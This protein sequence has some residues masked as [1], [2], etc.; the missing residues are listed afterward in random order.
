MKRILCLLLIILVCAAFAPPAHADGAVTLKIDDTNV[1]D[2]M[3]KS[4]QDGYVPRV[5]NG[6]ATLV[7]PL[8]ATGDISG[9]VITATPNLGDASSS[10]FVFKNYQKTI[11]L[12]DN[13]V[14]GGGTVSSYLVRFDFELKS[15]RVNGVYPVTTDISAQTADGESVQRS[16]T[17]YVTITDGKNP[18]APDKTPAPA[19]QPKI[20]ISGY[21][22][23]PDPVVA[24]GEFTATVTLKNTSDKKA[25]YNAFVTVSCDS[26]NFALKNESSTIPL[27]KIAKD[28][29]VDIEISYKTDL[30]TPAQRYNITLMMEYDNSDA[31]T[32][33]SQGTVQVEVTQPLNV[34]MD[35]PRIPESVNAGDTMSLS[36][37]VMNMGRSKVYNARIEISAPGLLPTKTAFIGDIEA[38]TA[39]QG[40][41]DIF[42]GMKSMTEGYKGEDKY[43]PTSGKI[44]LIYEDEEGRP[45]T[46][47]MDIFTMINEPVIGQ[48]SAKPEE[49]PDKESQW[50]ISLLI[51]G[52]AIAAITV[53]LV[54]RGKR[55]Q[56]EDI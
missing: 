29:T 38:G 21:T 44:T 28:G 18:N 41:M 37:Q 17:S 56:N 22:I 6:Y 19:H 40:K 24:G 36:F 32:L 30:E 9:N 43:G 46:Q 15:G 45:Y 39:A 20:I 54:S 16:F 5:S 52:A 51:G 23:D 7:L 33:S 34:Q 26:P 14:G 42:V 11:A 50:W 25:V 8:I 55:K 12:N 4:Y 47:E 48:V 1:Y 10:P 27:G 13:A 49:K 53:I 3:D 2:G 31:A 35:K